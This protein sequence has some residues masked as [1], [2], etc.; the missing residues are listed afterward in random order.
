MRQISYIQRPMYNLT[1]D[2]EPKV[3]VMLK[4]PIVTSLAVSLGLWGRESINFTHY[5]HEANFLY[6]TSYVYDPTNTK[7]E[8]KGEARL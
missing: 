4:Y 8:T 5:R 1:L 3:L 2:Y 6:P 7:T